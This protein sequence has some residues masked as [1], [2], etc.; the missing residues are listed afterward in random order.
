MLVK[1]S[2]L[3]FLVIMTVFA[4][5]PFSDEM[6]MLKSS[7]KVVGLDQWD[8][9]QQKSNDPL[10]T[11]DSISLSSSALKKEIPQVKLEESHS[12]PTPK[13]R[14]IRKRSR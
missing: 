12:E 13:I 3:F 4:Q 11:E 14:K 1:I 8:G 10:L 5:N 7:S 2:S 9:A 6:N